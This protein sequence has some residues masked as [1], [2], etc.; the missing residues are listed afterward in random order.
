MVVSWVTVVHAVYFISKGYLLFLTIHPSML[1]KWD[2]DGLMKIEVYCD[3]LA[4]NIAQIR[5]S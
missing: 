5:V 3:F 1:V 4:N 2:P